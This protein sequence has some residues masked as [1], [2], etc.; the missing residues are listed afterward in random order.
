MRRRDRGREARRPLADRD[1]H[2]AAECRRGRCSATLERPCGAFELFSRRQ[3]RLAGGIQ[4]QA[5]GQAVE[6]SRPAERR[7][8]CGQATA[9]RRLAKPQG[10]AGGAERT[11]PGHRK[12]DAGI[13]PVET[14]RCR[15]P[16]PVA[17]ELLAEIT[18]SPGATVIRFC[19]AI[20]RFYRLLKQNIS[21]SSCGEGPWTENQ[22]AHPDRSERR[23][24]EINML[25]N[26]T[27]QMTRAER[28][29]IGRRVGPIAT[30]PSLPANSPAVAAGSGIA[31]ATSWSHRRWCRDPAPDVRSRAANAGAHRRND[32]DRPA[33]DLASVRCTG[34]CDDDDR[35]AAADGSSAHPM[36]RTRGRSKINRHDARP[37]EQFSRE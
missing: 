30:A 4:R 18:G 35:N 13:V 31:R 25:R 1:T 37:V 32:H 9:D 16:A 23:T 34:R 29:G 19:I 10:P 20:S 26:R 17:A 6:Q 2:R 14:A 12:K 15:R 7:F 22:H 21:L 24:G 11:I 36:S 3:Q 28:A 27:P 8:E 5:F 33:G